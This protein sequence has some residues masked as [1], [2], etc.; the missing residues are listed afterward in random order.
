MEEVYSKAEAVKEVIV[1]MKWQAQQ[2]S[3][4]FSSFT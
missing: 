1:Q 3:P 4:P 2:I